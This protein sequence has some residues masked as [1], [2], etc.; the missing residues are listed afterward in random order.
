MCSLFN[1]F[2]RGNLKT[3]FKLGFLYLRKLHSC[4]QYYQLIISTVHH[5]LYLKILLI[6][7]TLMHLHVQICYVTSLPSL[8]LH[9]E[10]LLIFSRVNVMYNIYIWNE[11]TNIWYICIY[12][13]IYIY[14][15][16]LQEKGTKRLNYTGNLFRKN[17]QLRGV[18]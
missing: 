16:E 11:T 3:A 17:L 15:K 13:Y 5:P 4:F 7:A 10:I 9:H 2:D 1:S 12:I 6:W 8:T 14:N 18:C